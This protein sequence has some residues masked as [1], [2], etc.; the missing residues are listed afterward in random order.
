MS[1]VRP[2]Y[3]ED[4]IWKCSS[5]HWE[6]W[7]RR[8]GCDRCN[9]AEEEEEQDDDEESEEVDDCSDTD[10]GEDEDVENIELTKDGYAKDGFVVDSDKRKDTKN[11]MQ[12]EDQSARIAPARDLHTV[13]PDGPQMSWGEGRALGG[14]TAAQSATPPPVA[15][16]KRALSQAGVDVRGFVEKEELVAAYRRLKAPDERAAKRE[17]ALR[18]AELRAT[19]QVTPNPRAVAAQDETPAKATE[20]PSPAAKRLKL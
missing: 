3:K 8:H 9:G 20:P 1:G 14:A 13:A 5:C 7:S 15:E 16:M 19:P 2:F 17:A 18:A 6:V 4:G 10:E 12:K 11:L